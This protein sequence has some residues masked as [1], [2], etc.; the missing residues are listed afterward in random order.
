MIVDN[1]H[2][3]RGIRWLLCKLGRHDYEAACL[4]SPQQV[5]LECFYCYH[6]R[7]SWFSRSRDADYHAI[8]R[9]EA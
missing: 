7:L 2:K 3:A 8:L 1:I 9:G 6:M 4:A 5:L